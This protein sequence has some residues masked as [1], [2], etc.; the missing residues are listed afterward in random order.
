MRKAKTPRKRTFSF[1]GTKVC[2]VASI[3]RKWALIPLVEKLKFID[4]A[5][6]EDIKRLRAKAEKAAEELFKQD[7]DLRD[8]VG[9]R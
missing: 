2:V 1:E 5:Y 8:S 6:E 9:R 4:A 7:N 3:R